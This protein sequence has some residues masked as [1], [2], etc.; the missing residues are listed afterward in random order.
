VEASRPAA[1]HDLERIAELAR[2]MGRELGAMKGGALWSTREARPEPL[3]ESY[4]ALLDRDDARL[5]VG[6]LDDAVVGFGAAVVERLRSGDRLGVITDLFVEPEARGVG[7]GEELAGDLV[8]FC[9]GHDCVGI[10]AM[11]LPGHRAAKNFFERAG[12][13]ARAI[14]MHRPTGPDDENGVGA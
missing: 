13:T 10:D 5:I 2:L 7:L 1:A 4:R 9:D 14:V 11:A 8:A 12:F 3:D 6:T